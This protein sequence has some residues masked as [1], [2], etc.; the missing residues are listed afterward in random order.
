MG[1]KRQ[2]TQLRLAFGE[3]GRSEAA[4]T[5]GEGSE[6]PTAK[7]MMESPA[8]NHPG[9]K[10]YCGFCE[11]PSLLAR[12]DQWV[13]QRLRSV[14]GKQW[15]R[16]RRRFANLCQKGVSSQLAAPTAG[17]SHRPWRIANS[18]A[19]KYAFPSACFNALGLPQLFAGA[20]LNPAE[21]PHADPHVRR[22]G[23]GGAATLPP[24]PI[25]RR[26][27]PPA[28]PLHGRGR[29]RGG[30]SQI[31]IRWIL[32]VPEVSQTQFLPH[33]SIEC[34]LVPFIAHCSC[35]AREI[36]RPE[37]TPRFVFAVVIMR[38]ERL[39]DMWRV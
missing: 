37:A 2:K 32:D 22:S 14:I 26:S 23:S 9:G 19:M 39:P 16:G 20:S 24:M 6:T 17:S 28:W 31:A 27:K 1:G 18:P 38:V 21:P 25:A 11:T 7:R 35:V 36:Q 30:T 10:G 5:A 4:R 29:I 15:K 12:P 3:E 33:C 8:K 34:S 13:R